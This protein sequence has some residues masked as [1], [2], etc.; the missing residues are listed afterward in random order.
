MCVIISHTKIRA[1]DLPIAIV[2]RGNIAKSDVCLILLESGS[3]IFQGFR[4]KVIDSITRYDV[5]F[6]MSISTNNQE[7]P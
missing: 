5:E 4:M 7:G 1:Y 6:G 2:I 3:Y